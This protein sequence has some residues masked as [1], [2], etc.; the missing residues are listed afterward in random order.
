MSRTRGTDRAFDR[1]VEASRASRPVPRPRAKWGWHAMAGRSPRDLLR[2]RGLEPGTYP[3]RAEH[4]L[5]P[6][7]AEP[8][9]AKFGARNGRVEQAGVQPRAPEFIQAHRLGNGEPGIARRA[10]FPFLVTWHGCQ[11]ERSATCRPIHARKASMGTRTE[12]PTRTL[13]I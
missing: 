4:E 11:A 6:A 2:R 9:R 12:P 10:R 13:G 8:R 7:D 1:S 3:R 5:S